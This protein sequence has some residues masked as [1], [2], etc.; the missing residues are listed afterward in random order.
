MSAQRKRE[1]EAG[2][3]AKPP[4]QVHE[5]MQG[6]LGSSARLL[7]CC[8]ITCLFVAF[9][10]LLGP[11]PGALGFKERWNTILSAALSRVTTREAIL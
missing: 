7:G 5:K 10:F 9:P 6:K 8:A 4:G 11:L 2:T 1:N 3:K